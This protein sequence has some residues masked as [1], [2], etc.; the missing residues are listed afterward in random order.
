MHDLGKLEHAAG[1]ENGLAAKSAELIKPL[2]R[3]HPSTE[4]R[5]KSHTSLARLI[6][7]QN[8]L[9]YNPSGAFVRART[10]HSSTAELRRRFFVL[11]PRT[12]QF[13]PDFG[14]SARPKASGFSFVR[15]F[16]CTSLGTGRKDKPAM[17]D[18]SNVN[19][20]KLQL[21]SD[22]RLRM[23]TWN[24]CFLCHRDR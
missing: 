23:P 6:A 5:S 11:M 22:N 13:W 3:K 17:R 1:L 10:N 15:Y 12:L 14:K 9:Q 7:A 18:E 19:K 16:A 20:R 21:M 8:P 24:A 2:V 4:P